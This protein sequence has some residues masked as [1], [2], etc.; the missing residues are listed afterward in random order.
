M[1]RSLK[2]SFSLGDFGLA[3]CLRLRRVVIP[4]LMRRELIAFQAL[5][6]WPLY[7]ATWT[8]TSCPEGV[9][10]CAT[11]WGALPSVF[12]GRSPATLGAQNLSIFPRHCCSPYL[13]AG[14][15]KRLQLARCRRR[16]PNEKRPLRAVLEEKLFT[17][18]R[19]STQAF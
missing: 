6:M 13:K 7:G 19:V 1:Q 8:N 2:S 9:P 15:G 17:S 16:G 10:N 5:R 4:G 12:P 11:S 14:V 18:W 3:L